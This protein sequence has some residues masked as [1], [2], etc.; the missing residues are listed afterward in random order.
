[1]PNFK[2]GDRVQHPL[3]GKGEIVEVNYLSEDHMLVRYFKRSLDAPDGFHKV[4]AP[5]EIELTHKGFVETRS[6]TY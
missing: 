5:I 4:T 3:Y 2:V 1:M 6:D